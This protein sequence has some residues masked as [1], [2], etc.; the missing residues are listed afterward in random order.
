MSVKIRKRFH[1][2]GPNAF[3]CLI[4]AMI[5]S[6]AKNMKWIEKC[7]I[8]IPTWIFQGGPR[9]GLPTC[10]GAHGHTCTC[11][12]LSIFVVGSRGQARMC[13]HILVHFGIDTI[14]IFHHRSNSEDYII[15]YPL[16]NRL[17]KLFF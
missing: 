15:D 11:V 6:E 7:C 5:N 12:Y 17:R 14:N 9:P 13:L 2:F 3:A 4:I 1:F 8:S 10:G 16:A